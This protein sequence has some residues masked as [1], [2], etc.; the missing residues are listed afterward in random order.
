MEELDEQGSKRQSRGEYNRVLNKNERRQQGRREKKQR[1]TVETKT[2]A[3][4]DLNHNRLMNY[5][6]SCLSRGPG[7][8]ARLPSTASHL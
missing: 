5:T 6:R 7:G 8:R 3:G 4:G 1:K 2:E